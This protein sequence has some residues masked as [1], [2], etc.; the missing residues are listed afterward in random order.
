MYDHR[1]PMTDSNDITVADRDR[2]VLSK[3]DREYLI[4]DGAN[5]KN[6][7][8]RYNVRH[9]IHT[10]FHN[11]LLDFAL[12]VEKMDPSDIE[13]AFSSDDTPQTEFNR[14]LQAV[15]E[16]V[17]QGCASDETPCNFAEILER[18]VRDAIVRHSDDPPALINVQFDVEVSRD[19]DTG[20]IREKY[21]NGEWLTPNEIGMLLA[22]G[23]I[24]AEEAPD[25]ADYSRSNTY[26]PDTLGV[27]E[28]KG[29]YH[30][31]TN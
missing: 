14:A 5:L 9:R 10:R 3:A 22:S 7:A 11:A 4:T 12:I 1:L 16:V 19:L 25:L 2:G 18:G 30:P 23:E 17:Y 20:E 13:R 27:M 29:T 8:T 15:I 31:D 28:N 24:S 26:L 21:E 6:D